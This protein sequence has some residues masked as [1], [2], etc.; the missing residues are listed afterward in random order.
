MTSLPQTIT[1]VTH[2]SSLHT[3]N[4]SA[5]LCPCH[6]FYLPSPSIPGSKRNQ[7]ESGNGGKVPSVEEGIGNAQEPCAET[8]VYHKEKAKEYVHRFY[9]V[10]P[11]VL[12][13]K[14]PQP[15]TTKRQFLGHSQT[16]TERSIEDAQESREFAIK[17]HAHAR[18]QTVVL[19]GLRVYCILELCPYY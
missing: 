17:S 1:Q 14:R 16:V 5:Y 11:S 19:K 15:G 2:S 4:I 10:E 6:N 12:R 13:P 8:E 9:L 3:L 7:E 18:E